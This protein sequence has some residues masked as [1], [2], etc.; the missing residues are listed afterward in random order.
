MQPL[1]E[2]L[3]PLTLPPS[4]EAMPKLKLKGNASNATRISKS[5]VDRE[6]SV[7]VQRFHL[8]GYEKFVCKAIYW[9]GL[10]KIHDIS[11]RAVHPSVRNSGRFF[12]S[13]CK[14]EMRTSHTKFSTA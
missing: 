4:N 10:P 3:T 1:S 9:L 13:A 5:V 6:A 8:D 12:T 14:Q 11:H 7:L 2:I